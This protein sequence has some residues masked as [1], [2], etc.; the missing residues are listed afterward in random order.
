M[1]IGY[2]PIARYLNALP[3]RFKKMFLD[4]C[5]NPELIGDLYLLL[6]EHQEPTGLAM[7]DK[8]KI[9]VKFSQETFPILEWAGMVWLSGQLFFPV[10]KG[11]P[12]HPKSSKPY[13]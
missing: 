7:L 8:Q 11:D 12:K 4:G 10:A 3:A 5:P 6:D 13:N 2:R 9:E 1:M